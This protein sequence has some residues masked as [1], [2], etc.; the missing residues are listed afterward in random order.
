MSG[1]AMIACV[2]PQVDDYDETLSILGN[3]SLASKIREFHDV[4]RVAS[5]QVPNSNIQLASAPAPAPAP[6]PAAGSNKGGI[7]LEELK[8][9]RDKNPAPA[10]GP[11]AAAGKR[12]R[13]DSTLATTATAQPAAGSRVTRKISVVASLKSARE[14]QSVEAPVLPEKEMVAPVAEDEEEDRG[15]ESER[16]RLRL[17][18]EG[19]R[20]ENTQLIQA[21][22]TREAEIRAEVSQEMITRSAHML[23]QIQELR[24]KLSNYEMQH[25]ND[26]TKS[27]RKARKQQ[28]IEAQEDVAMDLQEAEDE[29]IRTKT[30]YEIAIHKLQTENQRLRED[31]AS[32]RQKLASYEIQQ[33]PSRLQKV[34]SSV[35]KPSQEKTLEQ[36]APRS[37]QR[38]NSGKPVHNNGNE[39]QNSN[40]VFLGELKKS[41]SRSPL[42]QLSSSNIN[43]MGS[44]SPP[45]GNSP[46]KG[47]SGSSPSPMMAPESSMASKVNIS[48]IKLRTGAENAVTSSSASGSSGVPYFKRLRSHF[49][50]A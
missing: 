37:I 44:Q 7:K 14:T 15:V 23:Q 50:R 31:L 2:N 38:E 10:A 27:C 8:D 30:E 9:Y 20:E 32:A 28:I 49:A 18:V 39:N 5:Q 40:I 21:T 26:V 29:L 43:A 3:A 34:L 12:K 13:H 16:K 1:V 41:P 36:D 33:G 42:S 4:G 47:I 19:L 45:R 46:L 11:A 17:E 35:K 25:V 6:L 22:M 24:Q 48:P